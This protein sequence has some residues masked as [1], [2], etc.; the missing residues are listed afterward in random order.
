MFNCFSGA[1][2]AGLLDRR[3]F[4]FQ[5]Q[6]LGHPALSLDNLARVLPALPPDQ[7]MY[8]QGL[9][10]LSVNFDRAHI[11]HRNDLGLEETIETLRTCDSYIAV[12][13]PE[14]H[15]SFR[16]LFKELLADVEALMR[17]RGSGVKATEPMLWLFIAS[18]NAVTP[19]HFDR[20]SN[21]LMQFRGS[22]EVAVF[23][24][25][26]DEVIRPDEYEVYVAHAERRMEWRPE[27]DRHAHKFDFRPG[28]ALHIPFVGGHYV[29]N[30]PEDVSISLSFFFH[31]RDTLQLTRALK[32]NH[33]LRRR[34]AG[35]GLQPSPVG[36]S[37]LRDALK[38]RLLYPMVRTAAAVGRRRG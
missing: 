27:A 33:V 2:D 6:L 19:F 24:P 12:R 14:V 3:P 15:A 31:S 28:D 9:R 7:V 8:S 38:A 1:I 18:P 32:V 17:Q 26:N 21:V 16:P 36:R 4:S 13:N 20:Y 30:G 10:D 25:W 35:L 23:E 37:P 11:D 5:H 34:L 22:K 29:K